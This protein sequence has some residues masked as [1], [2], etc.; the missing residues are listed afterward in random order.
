V[1]LK[2]FIDNI[3]NLQISTVMKEEDG[4][5][6]QI[7]FVVPEKI[8]SLIKDNPLIADLYLTDI[9]YYP[10]ASQ[11]FR[12]RSS[13]SDQFI[14]IYCIGGKGEIR[15]GDMT[16]SISSDQ[17]FIIPP[18]L[19]HTYHSDFQ[20]PMVDLLDTFF[21]IESRSV[22]TVC[23]SEFVHRKE[24][25]LPA[26]PNG[27]IFFQRYSATSAEDSTWKLWSIPIYA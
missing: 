4:F 10:Q 27:S 22:F 14:L 24:H 25:R 11:H 12:E 20:K 18:H 7:S 8:I 16:Y 19:A 5:P 15:L 1:I 6:G 13:G 3:A 9:G 23:L 21:G 2:Q 26:T 17:C